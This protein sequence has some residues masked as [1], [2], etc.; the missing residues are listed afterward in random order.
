MNLIFISKGLGYISAIMSTAVSFI[1]MM[2]SEVFQHNC[3]MLIII[4]EKVVV[5]GSI[6]VHIII[7]LHER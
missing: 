4:Y 7:I 3:A 5:T 6:P 2:C 1:L